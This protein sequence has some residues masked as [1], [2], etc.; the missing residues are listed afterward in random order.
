MNNSLGH[1]M[2]DK[3]LEGAAE[4]IRAFL[5]KMPSP[6]SGETSS[7]SSRRHPGRG[8]NQGSEVDHRGDAEPL[9][10]RSHEAYITASI[11][12]V[13]GKEKGKAHCRLFTPPINILA[14]EHPSMRSDLR[15]VI[16]H[17]EFGV[18]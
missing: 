18:Y 6:V 2:G 9:M 12:I 17:E 11:G 13:R 3:L 1:K 8:G 15:R 16:K 7:P 10:L 14:L 4:H 5:Q